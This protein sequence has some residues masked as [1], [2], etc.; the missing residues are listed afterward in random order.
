VVVSIV[1]ALHN[2][3]KTL[4]AAI[5]SVLAQTLQAIELVVIDDASS[6][7]SGTIISLYASADDRLVS[8]RSGNRLGLPGL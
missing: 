1:L 7:E 3:A 5:R 6:D 2:G 4:D 8:E